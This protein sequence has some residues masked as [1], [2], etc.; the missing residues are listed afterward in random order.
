MASWSR[1]RLEISYRVFDLLTALVVL[2]LI[3][4]RCFD[5]VC[6]DVVMPGGDHLALGVVEVLH[7][8]ADD[9]RPRSRALERVPDD[10]QPGAVSELGRRTTRSSSGGSDGRV[11]DPWLRSAGCP[12]PDR[13]SRS[14][15]RP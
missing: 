3:L 7:R 10:V 8:V 13:G 12:R 9:E 4:G 5:R 11:S 15:C 2:S 6:R 14:E 1:L